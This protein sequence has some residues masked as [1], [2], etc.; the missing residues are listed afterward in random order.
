MGKSI[1]EGR[2]EIAAL[3]RYFETNRERFIA[4][5]IKEATVRQDLIDGLLE[6]L[7]WDVHNKQIVA[8]QY[9]EIVPEGNLEIDGQ[10]RAPDYTIRVGT[11][12]RFYVEAKNCAVNVSSDPASAFQLRRYGWNGKLALSILTNF[13]ELAVY[14]CTI[15]P[16]ETDKPSRA[17]T[18]LI[19]YDEY[20]EKWE[21]LWELFS[22]DAVLSGKFDQ[23]AASKRKRRTSEVDAE[24]LKEIEA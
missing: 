1:D 17:K 23:Y 3:C 13:Q 10:Q 15:R 5:G 18:H 14:D 6:A 2:D 11:L 12:P 4:P 21:E 24:F 22:R 20:F 16:R 8:P 9:R 7:G 19:R